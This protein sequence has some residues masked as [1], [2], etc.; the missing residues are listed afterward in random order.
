MAGLPS[1]FISCADAGPEGLR[2]RI[3][4]SLPSVLRPECLRAIPL[5]DGV[6]AE[7]VCSP[8]SGDYVVVATKDKVSFYI[9]GYAGGTTQRVLASYTPDNDIMCY[10]LYSG[11]ETV[12]V[13]F[14]VPAGVYWMSVEPASEGDGEGWTF[15]PCGH[16]SFPLSLTP[17]L[18]TNTAGYRAFLFSGKQ[19]QF[20]TV[21]GAQN[22]GSVQFSIVGRVRAML[23]TAGDDGKCVCTLAYKQQKVGTL[24]A[25]YHV[26]P[27]HGRE[28]ITSSP[29][30]GP[31]LCQCSGLF[32]AKHGHAI[33]VSDA[34]DPLRVVCLDIAQ[35]NKSGQHLTVG[36]EPGSHLSLQPFDVLTTPLQELFPPIRNDGGSKKPGEPENTKPSRE[37]VS[38]NTAIIEGTKGKSR[39]YSH[40]VFDTIVDGKVYAACSRDKKA[41]EL[42]YESSLILRI[43]ILSTSAC[44]ADG[45]T[46]TDL[47][48]SEPEHSLKVVLSNGVLA[49]YRASD[50]GSSFLHRKVDT[51]HDP[52]VQ[53][54][55]SG[56]T[57]YLLLFDDHLTC[58][59]TSL[60]KPMRTEFPKSLHI[61][62]RKHP[63]Y[64]FKPDGTKTQLISFEPDLSAQNLVLHMENE[65]ENRKWDV[66]LRMVEEPSPG[67]EAPTTHPDSPKEPDSPP[68]CASDAFAALG[69]SA[70]HDEQDIDPE[71]VTP[72][73]AF[74]IM[75]APSALA[76]SP[77]A[78][79]PAWFQRQ[80]AAGCV[81]YQGYP[82]PQ[83]LA[84]DI[85]S[86]L[87]SQAILRGS[88]DSAQRSSKKGEK[89]G[90]GNKGGGTDDSYPLQTTQPENPQPI[91][92]LRGPE[93]LRRTD[94]GLD[95]SEVERR[96]NERADKL[97]QE[98]TEALRASIVDEL[99]PLLTKKLRQG[100][101]SEALASGEPPPPVPRGSD[102]AGQPQTQSQTRSQEMQ[103]GGPDRQGE[104]PAPKGKSK[105][106]SARSGKRGPA[107]GSAQ[108][109]PQEADI[110]PPEA[111]G[112]AT[113]E[114]SPVSPSTATVSVQTDV[115]P[116]LSL[117]S[118]SGAGS[119][120]GGWP[121]RVER[122]TRASAD[123][124]PTSA[125]L[126]HST[127]SQ[128]SPRSVQQALRESRKR[129]EEDLKALSKKSGRNSAPLPALLQAP[130]KTD[131]A[132]LA[133]SS[134]PPSTAASFGLLMRK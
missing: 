83:S 17:L 132:I 126:G 57:K 99:T 89:G 46:I 64:K 18:C 31:T 8:V 79:Q 96:A 32:L 14:A 20:V 74:P 91:T 41:V 45:A 51:K 97:F 94:D 26:E 63:Q 113:S 84:D 16:E 131:Q 22:A 28:Q 2:V 29:L 68:G 122:T 34:A 66:V 72:P 73:F 85:S 112:Q 119:G 117:S 35:W 75:H 49:E 4:D 104:N 87:I 55:D 1:S 77:L 101:E 69:Y 80:R 37:Y 10:S 90:K 13:C 56:K 23:L 53:V 40:A 124:T 54:V 118:P 58:L 115:V 24:A 86:S 43:P 129:A 125:R 9:V 70:V 105:P 67:D 15:G 120:K 27:K 39:L 52:C 5:P 71:H 88:G 42:F 33:R 30:R 134:L 128:S 107:R 60:E 102:S 7:C 62:G 121:E 59:M 95:A 36:E 108:P 123:S 127:K 65:E 48:L 11:Q 93:P 100:L 81:E 116:S 133:I 111:Q 114:Q 76:F 44:R 38:L 109:T 25:E 110:Q 98:K 47:C 130:V 106:T 3:L 103:E 78:A 50:G 82:A 21:Y 19:G 12:E 61:F 92:V 6:A